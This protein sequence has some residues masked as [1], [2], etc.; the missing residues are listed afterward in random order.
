[1]SLYKEIKRRIR[2]ADKTDIFRFV[3][4][5]MTCI[6]PCATLTIAWAFGRL[7]LWVLVLVL[8][9]IPPIMALAH[10]V[11]IKKGGSIAGSLYGGPKARWTV[12][13]QLAGNLE[14]IRYSKRQGRFNEALA[15]ANDVLKH[16]PHDPDTLFLKAQ[17]LHEGFGYGQ[18]AKKC[19]EIIIKEVP[20]SETLH[21]WA[22]S[23]Y[24]AITNEREMGKD[25]SLSGKG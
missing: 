24:E 10:M 17:I 19:L 25:P 11:I 23:L 1:M 20:T 16:L 21:R 9:F 6:V 13:E 18:S 3:R 8:I 7:S 12:K 4:V 22:T 2:D 14:K 5:W 15:L